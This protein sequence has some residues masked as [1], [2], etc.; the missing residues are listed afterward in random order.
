MKQTKILCGQLNCR[1]LVC[2]MQIA[3]ENN[4][5]F[6]SITYNPCSMSIPGHG[7]DG[8]AWTVARDD[9]GRLP[10]RGEGDDR[11]SVLLEGGIDGCYGDGVDG[12]RWGTSEA[13]QLTKHDTVEHGG[14][15]L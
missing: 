3:T 9:K 14:L 15:S 11:R 10:G 7:N 8:A 4:V 12:H 2:F 13:T 5:T 6:S 1:N